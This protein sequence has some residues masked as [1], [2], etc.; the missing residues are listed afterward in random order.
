MNKNTFPK[1][2]FQLENEI[3]N[4]VNLA[5]LKSEYLQNNSSY[6]QIFEIFSKLCHHL[7]HFLQ[8]DSQSFSSLETNA[9][10]LDFFCY[11]D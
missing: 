5:K 11:Q 6:C 3:C 10:L 9:K 8:F 7:F 4:I 2:L 1:F